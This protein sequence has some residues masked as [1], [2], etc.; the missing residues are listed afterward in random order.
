MSQI[1]Y[2]T[3]LLPYK[4][5]TFQPESTDIVEMLNKEGL[6]HWKLS[7]VMVPSALWG[8]SNT[9]VAILERTK[10]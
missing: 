5:S 8:R 9:V 4:P 6:E 2:K 3:I 10:Q 7:Q 1:E